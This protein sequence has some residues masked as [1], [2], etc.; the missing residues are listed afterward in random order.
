MSTEI[1]KPT[2]KMKR[3]LNVVVSV[4]MAL[5]FLVLIIQ[6]LHISTFAT[7]DGLPYGQYAQNQQLRSV[8]LHANRGTI[9]DRNMK[10]LAQSNT[11]HTVFI[12]PNDIKTDGQREKI[13]KGLSELLDV[14]YD[15]IMEKTKKRNFYEEIKRKIEPEDADKITDWI[16]Q[17]SIRAVHLVEDSKRVYPNDDFASS[18]IGFT[19]HDNQ[20]LY[21]LEAYYNTA[22]KGVNGVLVTAK[23]ARGNDMDT[24]YQKRYSATDGNSLVLTIDS[25]IQHFLETAVSNAAKTHRAKNRACGVAIDPRT[26]EI[27]AMATKPDFNLNDPFTIQDKAVADQI[28]LITDEKERVKELNEARER[29]WKNKVITE[30]YEPG[31]VFKSITAAAAIEEKTSSLGSRFSCP[32]FINVAGTRMSCWRTEGHGTTD[33]TEA[34]VVS[35]N[36]AFVTIGQGLGVAN[37]HKYLRGFGITEKTGI[38]LPGEARSITY[39]EASMREVELASCSFGQS[40][41][42]TPMEM[43]VAFSAVVNGGKVV[44]PYVVKQIIDSNNNVVQTTE[45]VIKRQVVSKET[46]DIMRT[47]LENVVTAGGGTNAYV[48]GFRIGGKSGTSQKLDGN[49]SDRISSYAAFGPVDDPKILVLIM[50]DEPNSGMVYGSVVAA[51]AVASVMAEALPYLGVERKY[52]EQ[53]LARLGVTVP[54]VVGS[55]TMVARNKISGQELQFRVIGDGV[56]VTR[57][58]PGNGITVNKGSTVYLYT[59]ENIPDEVGIVPSII[60]MT[61][62][63][64]N[65]ALTNAGFNIQLNNDVNGANTRIVSQSV[66]EGSRLEK[67]KIISVECIINDSQN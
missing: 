5:C 4:I 44:T 57:Q 35:C 18:V 6:V 66:P 64:A 22:L 1:V 65:L 34:L 30:L 9:Y 3:R 33:F 59:S 45:P 38:D 54:Y 67:G 56:T 49:D 51:P 60:G 39:K 26:G 41:K 61:A 28:A 24:S 8:T 48:K 10:V 31:S 2:W 46:S 25:S 12:S 16:A 7:K 53:E 40:N 62:A 58:I 14:D 36:P 63:Q 47:A 20:G 21:G 19:G 23:N 27:L 37:F 29:Q 43:A 11:V 13:S 50:V 42:I 17:E 52:T 32:G 55:E 15:T